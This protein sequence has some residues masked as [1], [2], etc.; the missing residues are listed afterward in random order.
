MKI[1]LQTKMEQEKK[2]K[3]KAH[4]ANVIMG[5]PDCTLLIWPRITPQ[6]WDQTNT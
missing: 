3:K 4:F 1:A 2:K 6:P 5:S